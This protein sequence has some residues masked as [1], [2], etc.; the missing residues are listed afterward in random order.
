MP[1]E[2]DLAATSERGRDSHEIGCSIRV[3]DHGQHEIWTECRIVPT[4]LM[5]GGRR[6][7]K[8]TKP[9]IQRFFCHIVYVR[10]DMNTGSEISS[11]EA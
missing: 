2:G 3:L 7:R 4:M 6:P 10:K 9:K 8:N 11:P 5:A 1:A